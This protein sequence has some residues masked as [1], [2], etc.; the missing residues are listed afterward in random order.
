MSWTLVLAVLAGLALVALALPVPRRVL[1]F[2]WHS[3]KYLWIGA[4]DRV[5][6][7]RLVMRLRGRPYEPLT[8]PRLLRL[9]FEDMGPT[10]LKFGQIIASSSGMFPDAYVKEFQKVLD[11]V[12]PFSFTE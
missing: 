12:R 4:L 9:F 8:R 10:F 5:G 2:F 6:V 3:S 1:A 11:R 7:R